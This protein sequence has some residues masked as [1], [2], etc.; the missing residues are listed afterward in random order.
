M[1]IDIHA[2][3]T[4]GR[5]PEFSTLLGRKPFTADILLKRMDMEGI[6]KSVLLPLIS[7]ECL[8]FYGVCGNQECIEAARKHPDRFI[9]FCNIDPR[10]MM[11]SD[12]NSI[13]RLI[14]VYQEFGCKGIGE[15]C[16]SLWIDDIRY[17]RLFHNAGE[18]GMPIIFHFK[19]EGSTS[20]GA[21]DDPGLPR[22]ERMVK[23]FPKTIFAGHA[24]CFW[25]EISADVTAENRACYVKGKIE[26]KGRLWTMF[27]ENRNLYGD[28]SAGS[29]HCA[30]SRD[31]EKGYE[32]LEKFNSQVVFGTDRFTSADEPVPPI[33]GFLKNG[34]TEGSLSPEAYEN[35]M[36]RNTER[37]LSVH[38]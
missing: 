10:S 16:A 19:P 9:A 13:M 7:P 38:A 3:I 18:A 2:H 35:I 11:N 34:L 5:F 26:K 31:P 24:P 6:D 27:A 36:H 17:Q 30:L 20:Y 23:M 28:I 12:D 8:D 37:I 1:I 29:A 15:M 32:F 33:L 22:F 21:I 14:K 25:N 4:Y